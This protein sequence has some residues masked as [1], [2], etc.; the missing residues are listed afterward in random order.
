VVFAEGTRCL[1]SWLDLEAAVVVR[2]RGARAGPLG[3]V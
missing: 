1:R 2:P 3:A